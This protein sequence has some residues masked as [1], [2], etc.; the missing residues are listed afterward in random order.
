[1]FG[2]DRNVHPQQQ[3][4]RQFPDW[5]EPLPAGLHPQQPSLFGEPLQQQQQQQ[6]QQPGDGEEGEEEGRA[7]E[8]KGSVCPEFDPTPCLDAYRQ[9]E[10]HVGA[11]DVNNNDGTGTGGNDNDVHDGSTNFEEFLNSTLGDRGDTE[12]FFA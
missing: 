4:S 1:M 9:Y 12:L 2:L 8:D 7:T 11:D 10:E 5:N 3:I 6:Q